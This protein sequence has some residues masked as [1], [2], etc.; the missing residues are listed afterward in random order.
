MN[1]KSREIIKWVFAL[2]KF[3]I[4]FFQA[5]PMSTNIIIQAHAYENEHN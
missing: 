5:F 3:M 4:L 1:V 2:P